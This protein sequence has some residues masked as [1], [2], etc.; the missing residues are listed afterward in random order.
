MIGSNLL[1]VCLPIL[2]L[3][4]HDA[5]SEESKAPRVCCSYPSGRCG[6]IITEKGIEY[7]CTKKGWKPYGC[8][9]IIEVEGD[10]HLIFRF[11]AERPTPC[12]GNINRCVYL[13]GWQEYCMNGKYPYV[14]PMKIPIAPYKEDL[15]PFNAPSVTTYVATY[16][17]SNTGPSS[18]N[19][20][21]TDFPVNKYTFYSSLQPQTTTLLCS[22]FIWVDSSGNEQPAIGNTDI[23][24]KGQVEVVLG[25]G[26]FIT[27]VVGRAGSLIDK[28]QFGLQ[29]GRTVPPC[30]GIYGDEK[31]VTPDPWTFGRCFMINIAGT[32]NPGINNDLATMQFIWSCQGR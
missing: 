6:E 5:A 28:L 11:L 9:K 31:D 20:S 16:L 12:V 27:S 3:L 14:K 19:M 32:T 15:S 7:I 18:F 17:G 4:C 13:L 24:I 22:G 29:S 10:D 23:D 2:I 30:G 8:P 21:T 25:S 1:S 26:D